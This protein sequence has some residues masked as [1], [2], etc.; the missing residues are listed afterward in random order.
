MIGAGVPVRRRARGL[1][2][3]SLLSLLVSG[4]AG[5]SSATPASTLTGAI[6]PAVDCTTL[7]S[8]DL[9]GLPAAA[10]EV[11]S[12]A[13]V[14]ADGH[15]FC[16]VFGYTSPQTYF[17]VKLPTATWQGDFLQEGC[18][19]LCGQDPLTD[20]PLAASGCRPATNGEFVLAADD[21]GHLTAN[22]MDGLWGK[23]D[24]TLRTV[25]GR[26][27]EHS[28]AQVAKALTARYYGRGPAHSFFDGCSDGGREALLL[29]ERYPTDFDGILAGAP[30]QNWA[31]L[32]GLYEPWLARANTDPAGHQVLTAEKLP[33]LHTAVLK[34]CADASDIILDPRQCAFDP[35]SLTC[36][37]GTD[38]ANC[39]TPAQV[40]TVR[41]LYLGPTDAA[42]RSLY[43]GGEPYGSELAWQGWLAQP[44]A[45]AAAP[46]D[47]AAAQLGLNYLKY[48]AFATNPPTGFTLADAPFTDAQFARLEQLGAST[49]DANDTDL[50]AFAGHGGKLIIYHGW[51]D[52]A[53]SPWST[54]DYYAGVEQAAGGFAASQRFSRLYL[55]PAA[56][57]CLSLPGGTVAADFLT[58]LV[59]WAEHGSGPGAVA[60][61]L[62]PQSGPVVAQTVRPYDALAPVTPAPGSLNGHYDYLGSR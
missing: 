49:Y 32:G 55:V 33:A 61:P 2:V 5:V 15:S 16:D 25:F 57:H 13:I 48:L 54:V 60:A 50:S 24:P 14:E 10:S 20:Q 42:G 21:E 56:N 27:S 38:A 8:V 4:F 18:G 7:T 47:T 31:A 9:T 30:A 43:D 26:T 45:D 19:G 41:E 58:P 62:V 52:Q 39:L 17:E 37:A 44:A 3:V 34:A 22:G 1:L 53:I 6:L 12:A 35:A 11:T 59:D 23:D 40:H 51:A 36:P 29:A 46:G 28:L